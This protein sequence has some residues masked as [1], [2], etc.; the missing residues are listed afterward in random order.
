MKIA[1]GCDH[2]GFDLKNKVI[3]HLKEL[4]HEVTDLGCNSKESCDY[5]IFGRAVG[6]AV[7]AGEAD[8][9]IVICSTGIGISITANKV[10]GI[11]CALCTND[12][13]A[14]MTRLHNDANV[15]GLGAFIVG[16][17]MAMSIVDTFLT[18]DFSGGERHSRRIHEIEEA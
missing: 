14:K 7:A 10:P 12:F 8:R 5:P 11:R 9:G 17:G 1:I 13:M 15:L 3:A 6:K 16:E 4:G 18:T 2:G